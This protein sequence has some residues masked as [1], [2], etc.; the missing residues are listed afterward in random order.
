[1]KHLIRNIILWSLLLCMNFK[2]IGQNPQII[3]Q[4]VFIA[5]DPVVVEFAL[6]FTS[7][8]VLHCHSALGSVVLYPEKSNAGLQYTIPEFMSRKSGYITWYLTTDDL[9][10]KGRIQILPKDSVEH[11][12]TYFGPPDILAGGRDY[13]MFVSV[14]TDEFDNPMPDSTQVNLNYYFKDNLNHKDLYTDGGIVFHRIFSPKKSG[15]L[16]AVSECLDTYS[17][18][19]DVNIQPALPIDFSI[20]SEGHHRYADGNQVMALKTSELVDSFDNVVSDGT[21]VE[22]YIKNTQGDVLRTRGVTQKGIAIA[23]IVHPEYGDVWRIQAI[24]PGMA[25]SNVID[26]NFEQVIKE[27]QVEFVE[28]NREIILGPVQSYMNQRIPDGF[29]ADIQLFKKGVLIKREIKEMYNG[30]VTFKL[31]PNEITEGLY[32]IQF[33][34]AGIRKHYQQIKL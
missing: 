26:V 2:S 7:E 23:E 8:Y 3:K 17:K 19:F 27:Y 12:E 14:P 9:E 5:G 29:K 32:D 6:S 4:D 10:F 22:F 33:E 25:K 30:Y 28:N 20:Y 11:V 31:D 15:R 13:S 16:F 24:V 34:V 18:E 21:M 1:M